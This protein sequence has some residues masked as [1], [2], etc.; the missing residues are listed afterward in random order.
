MGTDEYACPT[1][2]FKNVSQN[3]LCLKSLLS[4]INLIGIRIVVTLPAP[5]N[6]S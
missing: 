2:T 5:P 4:A 6:N 1:E 3:V